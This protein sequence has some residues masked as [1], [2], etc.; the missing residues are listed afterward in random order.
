M[1][2][3]AVKRSISGIDSNK[4]FDKSNIQ[5]CERI[6][7]DK[8]DTIYAEG[9][10]Q[11]LREALSFVSKARNIVYEVYPCNK[12]ID[13]NPSCIAAIRE[14]EIHSSALIKEFSRAIGDL[15]AYGTNREFHNK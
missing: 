15:V 14:T 3:I 9:T 8:K 10:I 11:K 5:D 6:N 2:A 7:L 12:E 1:K 13:E 4:I